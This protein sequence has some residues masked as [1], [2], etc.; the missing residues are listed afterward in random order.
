M[1]ELNHAGI[2]RSGD[3]KD[4][5]LL[6]LDKCTNG[7]ESPFTKANSGTGGRMILDDQRS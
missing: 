4:S 2:V 7:Q 6:S 5:L 3:G 1:A